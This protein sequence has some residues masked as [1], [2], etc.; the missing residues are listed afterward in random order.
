LEGSGS[1]LIFRYY[2]GISL[3]VLRK[4]TN[5]LSQD[6]LSQYRGL[7]PEPPEYEAEDRVV[8]CVDGRT[9]LKCSLKKSDV[10]MWIWFIRVMIEISCWLLWAR[11][12]GFIKS[13]KFYW[14]SAAK[15][16]F[17]VETV[18]RMLRGGGNPYLSKVNCVILRHIF[19]NN[20]K[21]YCYELWH[22]CN[23][24]FSALISLYS[25]VVCKQIFIYFLSKILFFSKLS[26]E[27]YLITLWIYVLVM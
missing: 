23:C 10:R 1:N 3:E 5:N 4:S 9:V 12:F 21:L 7:N 17:F 6:G 27:R 15:D 25:V 26:I 8:W 22:K 24:G 14:R 16:H 11:N 13:R 20:C 18:T 19:L 2:P